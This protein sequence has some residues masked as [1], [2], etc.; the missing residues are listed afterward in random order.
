MHISVSLL[1]IVQYLHVCFVNLS[2]ASVDSRKNMRS[3]SAGDLVIPRTITSFADRAFASRAW[4][5]LPSN[6]K[7]A[8]SASSFKRQLKTYLFVECYGQP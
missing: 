6:F 1:V 3:A 4:N 5:S 7:S 8:D 2:R